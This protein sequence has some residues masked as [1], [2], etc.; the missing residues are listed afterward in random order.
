MRFARITAVAA[1]VLVLGVAAI[2]L[3]G[4]LTMRSRQVSVAPVAAVKVDEMAAAE[5]LAGAVRFKTI[6]LDDKPNAS[7]EAFL[8]LHDYLAQQFPLVHRT[9]TLEKIGQY[10]LLYTWQGSD[11]SLKPIMLMAHQDVVPIAPGTEKDWLY[12]PFGGD[13]A[14][15]YVWGRGSWDDKSNLLA[16]LEALEKLVAAGASPK[17]TVILAS[18]HDEEVGG[19]LGAQAIAALL[20]TRGV[21]LEFVLD[22]GSLIAEGIIRG[23]ERPVALIGVAEKGSTTLALTAEGPPGHSSMP[24]QVSV[25]GAL[26]NAVARLASNQ[27]PARISGVA[28]EMFETLAPE[29]GFLNRVL[30]SNLWLTEPLVR[31][32]LE[33]LPSTNAVM[34]TTTA[35]TVINGGNKSNVLP[36]RAEAL[37]NFR[38][39]PGDSVA[40]VESHARTVIADPSIAVAQFGEGREPTAVSPSNGKAFD[41]IDRTIRET[42]SDAIVAPSLVIAGTDSRFMSDLSANVY[43]FEPIRAGADDLARFHGTNERVSIVNYAELIQFFHRL[44]TVSAIEGR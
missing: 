9:L 2:L 24:P 36:G 1:G 32:Q 35:L 19:A 22:E 31:S 27:M 34:R 37:V 3:F 42:M 29:M 25:I 7:A 12:E 13:I 38:I 41:L 23:I 28:R 43:R 18:G 26:S 6:S 14:D 16:V 4:A 30:L 39:L 11:P 5:R 33:K 17:R 15:G 10:S 21:Q 44:I 40:S 20:K 8:A